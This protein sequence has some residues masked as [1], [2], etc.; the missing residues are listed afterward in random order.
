MTRWRHD[1][2]FTFIEL[3]LAIALLAIIAIPLTIHFSSSQ[4]GIVRAS[5]RTTALNL[6]REKIEAV[7]AGGVSHYLKEIDGSPQGIYHDQ[8]ELSVKNALFQREAKLQLISPPQDRD[9]DEALILI[10]VKVTWQ[11]GGAERSVDLQ[12]YLAER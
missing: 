1:H 11:E 2:G 3:L 10:T 8:E 5:R 4:A 9:P 6:C 7:K 12:S